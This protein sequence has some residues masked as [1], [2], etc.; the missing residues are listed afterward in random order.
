ML[1]VLP[2]RAKNVAREKPTLKEKAT[3]SSAF[4][5]GA[6]DRLRKYFNPRFSSCQIRERRN[7]AA[8]VRGPDNGS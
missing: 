7:P 5:Q 6:G 2:E 1:A 3:E 4:A 8:E